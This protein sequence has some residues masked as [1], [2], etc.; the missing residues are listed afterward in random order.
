[1]C[2]NLPMPSIGEGF[3][4]RD[5]YTIPYKFC[6]Y[7]SGISASEQGLFEQSLVLNSLGPNPVLTYREGKKPGQPIHFAFPQ[8]LSP[9]MRGTVCALF[10]F[11]PQASDACHNYVVVGEINQYQG[12]YDN[13]FNTVVCVPPQN[14]H[15]LSSSQLSFLGNLDQTDP[16][17]YT[18]RAFNGFGRVKGLANNSQRKAEAGILKP[19]LNGVLYIDE[20]DLGINLN[21]WQPIYTVPIRSKR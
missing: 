1:M 2:E 12:E 4:L 10:P 16:S 9:E 13:L 18:L 5:G 14:S 21:P 6:L 3:I 15:S 7:S 20:Q 11:D 17:L 19:L 8:T